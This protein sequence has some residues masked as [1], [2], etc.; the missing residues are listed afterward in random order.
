[1]PEPTAKQLAAL[2]ALRK[3]DPNLSIEWD[4]DTGAP[5]VVR[6]L[7]SVAAPPVAAQSIPPLQ[8]SGGFTG[9]K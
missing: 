8:P 2:D 3:I 5:S 1:M 6:G 4:E 7:L 9:G